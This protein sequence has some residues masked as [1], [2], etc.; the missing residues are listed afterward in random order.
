MLGLERLRTM[1]QQ[2]THG[3]D[4]D[5]SALSLAA[6]QS[7]VQDAEA[8]LKHL[9]G[10]LRATNDA[11]ADL[12]KHF[13]EKPD[14]SVHNFFSTLTRFIAMFESARAD[15]KRM[16]ETKARRERMAK[17]KNSTKLSTSKSSSSSSDGPSAVLNEIIQRGSAKK[18]NK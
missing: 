11:F 9:S 16:Q 13:G 18:G 15:V 6:P 2:Q 10:E 3:G 14:M 1:V 17:S 5:S 8:E 7:F 4:M 12:L